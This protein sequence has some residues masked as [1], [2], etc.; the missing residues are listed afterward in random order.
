MLGIKKLAGMAL[1]AGLVIGGLTAGTAAAS[2]PSCGG[3]GAVTAW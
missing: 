3:T 1:A 2:P